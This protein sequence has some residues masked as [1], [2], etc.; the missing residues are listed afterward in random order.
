[1]TRLDLLNDIFSSLDSALQSGQGFKDWKDSIQPVLEQKGWWGEREVI[2]PKTGEIKKIYIGSRRLST[3]FKTN[4]RVAYAVQRY[5][6]MRKLVGA[7]YWRYRSMFLPNSRDTHKALSGTVLH[8]DDPFLRVNYPPNG[9][10]C[11]CKVDAFS[12]SQAK[13]RGLKISDKAPASIADK[14]WS[15]N[16]GA[17][18]TVGQ[19]SKLK[20]GGG[21][22]ALTPDHAL[23]KLSDNEIKNRFYK[24]LAITEGDLYI[25]KVGDPMTVGD[26]LFTTAKG[27]SKLKK[28]DRH[29][30]ID[31]LAQTIA[32]PDEIYLEVENRTGKSLLIK[33]MFRYFVDE[34]GANKAVMAIFT[35]EKDKTLGTTLYVV[36]KQQ[37]IG[38]K[39]VSKLI[40]KK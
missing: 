8:R 2:N 40:Y 17:G 34:N 19:L 39:R 21:L 18:S 26:D 25:D 29:L 9:W 1:V 6:S 24:T 5:Q 3:I 33:K 37:A 35:Y 30:Y 12:K 14:D 36:E 22:R 38:A 31:Q 28:L 20:L 16:V 10:G 23:D 13:R 11:V 4:M 7:V 27:E 15:H 32:E